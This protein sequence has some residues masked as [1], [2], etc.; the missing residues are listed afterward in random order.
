ML[1]LV[2]SAE[3]KV[4]YTKTHVVIQSG[5]VYHLDLVRH[6]HTDFSFTNTATFTTTIGRGRA[7]LGVKPAQHGDQMW[8]Y[9]A[10][11]RWAAA[12]KAGVRVDSKGL[13]LSDSYATMVSNR[14]SIQSG[15][16]LNVTRRYVGLKFLIG[17]SVHYGWAR[18][19][20]SDNGDIV[21]TLTGY[22]YE[23]TPGKSIVTGKTHGPDVI[24]KHG[25]L[26]ELA[27]GRR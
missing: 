15:P 21:A 16:W 17:K 12:L 4:V 6:G 5:Q 25:T 8:L 1:A 11:G 22:A 14:T 24:V 13:F 19:N 26:G 10:G 23:T 18:L 27:A 7:W 2:Q 9:S 3:A 20:V